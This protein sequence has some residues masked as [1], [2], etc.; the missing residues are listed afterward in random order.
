MAVATAQSAQKPI[1]PY[2]PPVIEEGV[3]AEFQLP[4]GFEPPKG[5]R[6]EQLGLFRLWGVVLDK[7]KETFPI[8]I[9]RGMSNVPANDTLQI[10]DV[11]LAINGKALTKDAVK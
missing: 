9:S 2:T 1:L 6:G 11:I 5:R 3:P 7:H 10:G 8:Y 4:E